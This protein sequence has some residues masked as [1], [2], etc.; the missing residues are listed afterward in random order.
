MSEVIIKINC[1]DIKTL[2]ILT[3][4]ISDMLARSDTSRFD[5]HMKKAYSNT[6]WG[7]INWGVTMDGVDLNF[8]K[9]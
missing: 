4:E 1:D 8:V 2:T 3:Q 7:K 9:C 6:E 5:N